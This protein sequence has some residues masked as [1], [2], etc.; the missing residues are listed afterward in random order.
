MK[1]FKK[2]AA[3][4]LALIYTLSYLSGLFTKPA[5]KSWYGQIIKSPLTPPSWAFPVAWTFLYTLIAFSLAFLLSQKKGTKNMKLSYFY[6][7]LGLNFLWT[8]AFFGLQSPFLGLCIISALVLMICQNILYFR[9]F[10]PLASYL[11]IP[12]FL[13]VLFAF[14]LNLFIFINN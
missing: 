6:I 4:C 5:L 14:Y 7:Q 2:N 1:N 12:Y 3:I 10:V 8:P 9:R 13:W 11:L